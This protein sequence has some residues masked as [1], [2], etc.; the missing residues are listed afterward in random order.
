MNKKSILILGG[1]GF[2]GS[3]VS[4]RFLKSGYQVIVIDGLL[5]NTGGRKENLRTALKKIQFINKRIEQV[6]NLEDYIN[7]VNLI[8][9]CMGWTSHLSAIKNP[10][11]DLE[12]NVLSHLRLIDALKNYPH[13][14]IIF[15]GSRGQYGNP[16]IRKIDEE[17]KMEPLDVQGT[18]KLTAENH[19]RIF[20]KHLGLNV[21]S[22]RLG[23]CFGPNQLID[24]EDIGLVGSFI[25]SSLLG[26]EIIVYGKD[27]KRTLCYVGDIAET[28]FRL[29]ED[30]STGFNAY[31][32]TGPQIKLTNLAAKILK[33]TGRGSVKI[34]KLP[35][36]IKKIDVGNAEID[37]KKI[38]TKLGKIPV[39]DIETGLK[40]TIDYFKKN[41]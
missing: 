14:N 35:E 10:R 4:L 21:S 7:K 5:K 37:E 22:L 40:E 17:A 9:D 25:K 30:M 32:L 38:K 6:N 13:K 3:H 8:I 27:R 16:E 18:H 15:L 39:T 33:I 29:A 19:F 31:N 26:K 28:I 1:S 11:Y 24:S 34:K 36:N 20:S 12:L 23:N 2:I 41:I